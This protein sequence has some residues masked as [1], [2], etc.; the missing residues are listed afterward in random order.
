MSFITAGLV[1]IGRL[2][3]SIGESDLILYTV[4]FLVRIN[5]GKICELVKLKNP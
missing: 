3:I 2:E 4:R 1:Q 5:P